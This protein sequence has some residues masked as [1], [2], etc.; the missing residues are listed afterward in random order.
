MIQHVCFDELVEV[1]CDMTSALTNVFSKESVQ[2]I[3]LLP[4]IFSTPQ[5]HL[6]HEIPEDF[7]KCA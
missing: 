1:G 2:L 4:V 5:E 6:R 7:D 3:G